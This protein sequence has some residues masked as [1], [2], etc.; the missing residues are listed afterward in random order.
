MARRILIVGG[1][2]GGMSAAARLLHC[3]QVWAWPQGRRS[4]KTVIALPATCMGGLASQ[5][6]DSAA[7]VHSCGGTWHRPE[8]DGRS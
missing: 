2:A 8:R 6:A 5:A 4:A 7:S 1:V 3:G